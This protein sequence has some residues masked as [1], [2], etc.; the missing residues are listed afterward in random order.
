MHELTID[1]AKMNGMLT[2]TESMSIQNA[3]ELKEILN[4]ALN[5][6]NALFI[7]HDSITECDITYLQLLIAANK[8]AMELKKIFKV[9]G[10]H[11]DPFKNL[12]ESTGCSSFAWMETEILTNINKE[13]GNE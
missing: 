6:V 2:L 5:E 7:T 13:T 3:A 12:I 4:N 8:S 1:P 9:I 11:S 10:G